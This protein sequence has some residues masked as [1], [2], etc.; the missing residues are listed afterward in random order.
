MARSPSSP[1]ATTR[2]RISIS[3][4]VLEVF[5]ALGALGGGLALMLGPRGEI[6][7]LPLSLLKGSVF[8]S[9]FV[10]GL[11]LF[12]ALGVC[13]MVVAYLVLSGHPALTL[14]VG[15]AL[16]IW[17]AVEIIIVGY[18]NTPPLQPTYIGLGVLISLM[19]TVWLLR[20]RHSSGARRR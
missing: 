14:A 3:A 17:M 19:G 6:V 4:V 5:L 7:P 11:I 2:T 20:E 15:G 12:I 16:L 13:P 10:P 8:A 1:Q 18:S 9:Y